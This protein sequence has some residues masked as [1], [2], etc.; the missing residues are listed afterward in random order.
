MLIDLLEGTG[1]T[2]KKRWKHAA[3]L[4]SRDPSRRVPKRA[5]TSSRT[6]WGRWDDHLLWMV[7]PCVLRALARRFGFVRVEGGGWSVAGVRNMSRAAAPLERRDG[8]PSHRCAGDYVCVCCVCVCVV[9]VVV[10]VGSPITS[11]SV[12]LSLRRLS[13]R[14]K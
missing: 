5:E 1:H 2:I 8:R 4:G 14:E 3:V 7:V 13:V 12:E 6:I 9:V 11:K 10:V